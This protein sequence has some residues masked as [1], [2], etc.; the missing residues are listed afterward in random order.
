MRIAG[1]GLIQLRSAAAISLLLATVVCQGAILTNSSVGEFQSLTLSRTG[2]TQSAEAVDVDD[3]GNLFITGTVESKGGIFSAYDEYSSEKTTGIA[4]IFI[5]KLKN[6]GEEVWVFQ[7][8]TPKDDRGLAITYSNGAVY[9]VGS[10]G[11]ALPPL[12]TYYGLDDVVV[13]KYDAANGSRLW[14]YQTGTE[15]RDIPS[16]VAIHGEYVFVTGLVAGKW[17]NYSLIGLHDMFLLKL[18]ASDGTL[19]QSYSEGKPSLSTYGSSIRFLSSGDFIVGACT[20]HFVNTSMISDRRLLR[21][22]SNLRIKRT[23]ENPKFSS[24]YTKIIAVNPE[25]TQITIAGDIYIDSYNKYDAF[26]TALSMDFEERWT[27]VQRSTDKQVERT[28]VLEVLPGNNVLLAGYTSGKMDPNVAQL[29]YWAPWVVILDATGKVVNL[30]EESSVTENDWKEVHGGALFQNSVLLVG[31]T[32]NP[33]AI[34]FDSLVTSF[35]VDFSSLPQKAI[36]GNININTNKTSSGEITGQSTDGNSD[37]QTGSNSTSS[38]SRTWILIGS[39][40]GVGFVIGIVATALVVIAIGRRR[41]SGAHSGDLTSP[42]FGLHNDGVV[43][44]RSEAGPSVVRIPKE[45]RGTR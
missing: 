5:S 15:G 6:N 9:V 7:T 40:I 32:Y 41:A 42:A 28:R 17:M 4:D 12:M 38:R 21:F 43:R 8:G 1:W 34:A 10:V 16:A 29:G 44:R 24:Y 26:A 11:G 20:S 39:C 31:R 25:E 14:Q 35:A 45:F 33:Q 3:E 18:R 37:I 27:V 19:V 36:V 22:D 2:I 30:T 23:W 13:L